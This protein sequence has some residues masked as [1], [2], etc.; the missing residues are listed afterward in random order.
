MILS[1]VNYLCEKSRFDYC[2]WYFVSI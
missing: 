1:R 2:I